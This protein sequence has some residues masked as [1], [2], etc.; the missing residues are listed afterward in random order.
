MKTQAIFKIESWGV[1]PIHVQTYIVGYKDK[2]A[3]KEAILT[4][5]EDIEFLVVLMQECHGNL[6]KA[7][8][9]AWLSPR[10]GDNSWNVSISWN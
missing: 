3:T 10:N 5:N 4:L 6:Y 8:K 9:S 7:D 1:I 2:P